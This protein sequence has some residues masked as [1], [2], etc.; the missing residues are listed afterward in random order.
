MDIKQE[1]TELSKAIE[2]RA[3]EYYVLDAPTISDSEYDKMFRSLLDLESKY[4]ECKLKNSP[5]DRVGGATL[6]GFKQIKHKR[7]MLSLD[8]AF[9]EE[10]MQ[11]FHEKVSK[12]SKT[13]VELVAEP[14]LDGLAISLFYK[15]GELEYAAT[16]GDGEVGEDVTHN[17]KTIRSIPLTLHGKNHPEEVEVRGEVFMPKKEFEAYNKRAISKGEKA[18]VNPRNAAAGALRQLDPKK[19]AERSLNF[20]AYSVGGEFEGMP[21]THF[22]TLK[23]LRKWGFPMNPDTKIIKDLSGI[24]KYY[25]SIEERRNSLPMDIDGI[26]FKV[27]DLSIQEEMGFISRTPRWAIARKFPAQQ[28]FTTLEDV[29]FQVG[30]T[31]AVTPVARLDPVF[32]GGVTVSNAT[33]HN[34]DEIARLG[35]KIG[36]RVVIERAGDVIPKISSV[37]TDVRPE[38]AKDIVM[39]KICP[40]CGSEVKRDI[41]YIASRA[42]R[43][44]VFQAVYRCTGGSNCPAQAVESIIHYCSKDR[45]DINGLGEKLIR[46][47]FEEG[48][49][50]NI[51]DIY[52]LEASDIEGLER[53]GKKSSE[54]VIKAIEKSKQTTFSKFLASLGIREVGDS[55]CKI[56]AKKM[57]TIEDVFSASIDDFIALDDFGEVMANNAYQFFNNASNRELMINLVESGV[58]WEE[59]DSSDLT[60]DGMTIVLTGTYSKIKRSDAKNILESKGAKVSGSVSSKTNLVIAGEKAGSKLTKAN[61][62]GIQVVDEDY[63]INLISS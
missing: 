6:K 10:E 37:I 11:S 50:G 56:I 27:N 41:D 38:S 62:L 49:I 54:N 63:L 61:E 43:H 18:F 25:K 21:E 24:G 30:R 36:D 5:T 40:C 26:V 32:V 17:I 16:R 20:I 7:K 19:T 14:K 59:E 31:G 3:Y 46:K 33:L 12:Y 23:V 44:T 55:A 4:P 28:E 51:G 34:M 15:N 8:N 35:V 47:L 42:K 53:Q 39:P 2:D 58:Y 1:I 13:P 29:D 45:M 52:K 9:D 48:I 22:D 60:L 57:K